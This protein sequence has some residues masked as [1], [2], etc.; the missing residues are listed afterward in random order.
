MEHDRAVVEKHESRAHIRP[1]LGPLE[2]SSVFRWAV[3][4]RSGLARRPTSSKRPVDKPLDHRRAPTT[5]RGTRPP[6][7]A[8]TGVWFRDGLRGLAETEGPIPR[9]RRDSVDKLQTHCIELVAAGLVPCVGDHP[10]GRDRARRQAGIFLPPSD[11]VAQSGAHR[12]PQ[13]IGC[14][15]QRN[16]ESTSGVRPRRDVAPVV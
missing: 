13:P 15:T 6:R 10:I 7:S 11:S 1:R 12:V 16:R 3:K 2:T 5:G 8:R 14:L 9:R 4:A